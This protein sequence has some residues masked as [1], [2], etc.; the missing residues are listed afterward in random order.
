MRIRTN[1][2]Q[3]TSAIGVNDSQPTF[4]NQTGKVFGVLLDATSLPKG[5]FEACGGWDGLGTIFYMDYDQAKE[6][7]TPDLTLCK[8]A[9]P[10]RPNSKS[11]P[12][13]GEIVLILD[14]PSYQSQDGNTISQKYYDTSVSIWNNIHHNS[15]SSQQNV[16]LGKTFKEKSNINTIQPFEGDIIYEGRFGTTLRF[17]SSV[18]NT[19]PILKL[20]NN[21]NFNAK[22]LEPYSENINQDGSSIYIS[23]SQLIPII[24]DRINLNQLSSTISTDKYN[25]NQIIFNSDRIVLNTKKDEI[26]LFAKTN[27]ELY[28]KQIISLNANERIHLNST[29]VFLGDNKNKVPDEPVLLGNKTVYLLNDL[30]RELSSFCSSLSTSVSTPAGSP[31]ADI[32]AAA[33][34]M[35][36]KATSFIKRLNNI[37]SKQV[38]IS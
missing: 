6:V 31:L 24:P 22:S 33:S 3:I 15:N 5:L 17:G 4:S 16:S 1:L 10:L 35:R 21:H 29:R 8:R 32:N 9:R 28:T 7:E 38:Y 23:S 37:T 30:L 20:V 11:F 19:D 2:S 36:L 14:L 34:K 26:L 27:I 12:V 13:I 18:S 25:S